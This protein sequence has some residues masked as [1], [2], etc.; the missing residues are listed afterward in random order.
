[1]SKI[2][3][4]HLITVTLVASFFIVPQSIFAAELTFKKNS[5]TE[6]ASSTIVVEVRIDP[7]SKRLNVVDG[8][9]G[10]SGIA[11]DKFSV[12]VENGHSIL[13]MWPTPPQYDA[14]KKTIIFTG[15]IPNGFDEEGLLFKLRISPR[16]SGDLHISYVE[17]SAYVNDGK[18]TQDFI[19]AKPLT[20]SLEKS[21]YSEVNTSSSGIP[22]YVYGII[23]LLV[24]AVLFTVFKYG[25]KK[26]HT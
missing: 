13:S 17:G 12:Q 22:M 11:S 21:A 25:V 4:T 26:I 15:G 14:D 2:F 24:G 19:S 23:F 10:F 9:I 5:N 18:G 20:L 16:T 3:A 7:Q 1:M 6:T 8:V